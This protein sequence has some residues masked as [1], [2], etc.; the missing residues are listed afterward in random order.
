LEFIPHFSFFS[1]FLFFLLS[2]WGK[3]PSSLH[4]E[5]SHNTGA[6]TPRH[7]NQTR[8]YVP[9]LAS[10]NLVS[11]TAKVVRHGFQKMDEERKYHVINLEMDLCTLSILKAFAAGE[12]VGSNLD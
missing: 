11:A 10:T 4:Q 1:T 9:Y 5:N 7:I 8:T 6:R 3:L 12:I 2:Y